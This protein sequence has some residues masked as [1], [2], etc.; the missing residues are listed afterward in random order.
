M[1]TADAPKDP[2]IRSASLGSKNLADRRAVIPIPNPP[3][4]DAQ[5]TSP[6]L[7]LPI[8]TLNGLFSTP[9]ILEKYSPKL[10]AALL[11]NDCGNCPCQG[12]YVG[13]EMLNRNVGQELE[14]FSAHDRQG[15]LDTQMW[16]LE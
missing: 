10:K 4:S 15:D 2:S 5:N 12:F 13:V 11:P 7:P 8:P 3:P 9:L 6:S 1:S 16:K 14:F